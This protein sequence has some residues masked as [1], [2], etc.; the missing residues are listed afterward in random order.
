M[1]GEIQQAAA[2]SPY[3][4]G[5]GMPLSCDWMPQTWGKKKNLHL[6]SGDTGSTQ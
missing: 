3:I 5:S 2:V 1:L 6:Q 4:A